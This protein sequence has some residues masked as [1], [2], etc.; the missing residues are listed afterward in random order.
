MKTIIY[1]ALLLLFYSSTF[2]QDLSLD[3]YSYLYNPYNIN[4]AYSANEDKLA[5]NVDNRQRSGVNTSN[6]MLG[7]R[8]LI[9]SNQ[10]VGGRLIVDN[11]NVFQTLK[12]DA[13]YGY[14]LHIS[15]KQ[16][17]AFGLSAGLINRSLNT[18][19]IN[20]Y[21]K[22]DATDPVL[23][24]VYLKSNSFTAGAGF[25]YNLNNFELAVAS[26][27]LVQGIQ[28]VAENF[29]ITT[30]YK[31]V[32]N[33]K[34]SI[35][36]GLFYFNIPIVKKLAGIQLKTEYNNKL[37]LQCG[38]QSNSDFNIGLGYKIGPIGFGYNYST[39]TKLMRSQSNGMHEVMLILKTNRAKP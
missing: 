14:C 16:K 25:V 9:G 13:T 4:P 24:S 35:T 39:G 29:N 36:P 22:L 19:K 38:Y 3:Y 12:I 23:Q 37:W 10:G 28:N 26:P 18:T 33:E 15:E 8:G 2:S 27:H 5:L 34:L 31:I 30:S 21:D 11:R 7:G 32:I 17:L 20:N 6:T 1:S